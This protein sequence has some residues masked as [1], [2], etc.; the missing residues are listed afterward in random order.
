MPE[1]QPFD[2]ISVATIAITAVGSIS[3]TIVAIGSISDQETRSI[4][5][6]VGI[7]SA[8][9]PVAIALLQEYRGRR[10]EQDLRDKLEGKIAALK[11]AAE[12]ARQ[13]RNERVLK[14]LMEHIR[15]RITP[16]E[17]EARV[18]IFRP[19]DAGKLV[20][21]HTSGDFTPSEKALQFD[22]HQGAVGRAYGS[23]E[24]EAVLADLD[25]PPHQLRILW[26]LDPAQRA[27][28]IHV[29][30]ILAVPIPSRTGKNWLGVLSVDS[31]SPLSVSGLNN[32]KTV[33]AIL[34]LPMIM[35]E[36]L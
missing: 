3:G 36:L 6:P 19:D 34:N 1:K 28:T 2:F 26:A 33:D 25:I 22:K 5:M 31:R 10:R 32:P 24:Y 16:Q 20:M 7:I 8:V 9:A 30:S 12:Q 15:H 11:S 23:Q 27:A 4:L 21:S 14:S 17:A 29:K 13:L 18:C 35:A